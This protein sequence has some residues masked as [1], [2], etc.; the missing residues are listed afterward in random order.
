MK[1]AV[2]LAILISISAL[3]TGFANAASLQENTNSTQAEKPKKQLKLEMVV[4]LSRHGERSSKAN[5]KNL[6]I[7]NSF[8]VNAKELTKVGAESHHSIG[9]ALRKEFIEEGLLNT[10]KY[11]PS[12]VYVQSTYKHRTI[13]SANS[14]LDGLFGK[15]L[16]WPPKNHTN[17]HIN[18]VPLKEDGMMMMTNET[19][20]R[21]SETFKAVKADP[22]TKEMYERNKDFLEPRIYKILR[23]KSGLVNANEADLVD[24]ANFID[25]TMRDGRE[26]NLGLTP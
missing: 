19:C 24:L 4:E 9:K 22:K 18:Y 2:F 25:W 20:L 17:Y 6:T 23:E 11:D 5:F 21:L 16:S 13:H 1:Q 3:L 15:D 26:V 7:G 10:K 12:E 8:D 14:Q